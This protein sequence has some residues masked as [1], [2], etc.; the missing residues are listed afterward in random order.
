MQHSMPAF[1]P[2]SLM[3]QYGFDMAGYMISS[4]RPRQ[5]YVQTRDIEIVRAVARRFVGSLDELLVEEVGLARII[6]EEFRLPTRVYDASEIEA[7]VVPFSRTACATPP[8]ARFVV[9][10]IENSLSYRTL[11]YPGRVPD[12]VVAAHNW[13]RQT[14][15]VQTCVGLLDPVFMA[16]TT[17]SQLAGHRAPSLHFRMGQRALDNIYVTGVRAWI[18]YIVLLA[19]SRR[20]SD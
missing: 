19:A 17:V 13:L 15:E 11:I 16:R 4:Q 18:S 20:V 1:N 3:G 7:A 10:L 2:H 8:P 5:L 9:T 6:A 14:H 12:N